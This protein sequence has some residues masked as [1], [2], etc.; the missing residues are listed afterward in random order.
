MERAM[1]LRHIIAF[2][3]LLNLATVCAAQEQPR[4]ALS[5]G[6]PWQAQIYTPNTEWTDEDRAGGKEQWELSHKCGGSLIAP[7]WVLTAAHC[8]NKKRIENG[9]RVRLGML[10]LS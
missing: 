1:V 5:R 3:C 7:E 9:Y 10:D 6:A 8:I 4:R 2:G